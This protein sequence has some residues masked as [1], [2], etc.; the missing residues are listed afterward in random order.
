MHAGEIDSAARHPGA[1]ATVLGLA[2][3]SAAYV[4][5]QI[6]NERRGG[7]AG[8]GRRRHELLCGKLE[9]LVEAVL[10]TERE[11]E[12]RSARVESDGRAGVA[13]LAAPS[14]ASEA[15]AP[16]SDASSRSFDAVLTLQQLYFPNLE[17]AV[18]EL[19]RARD[20]HLHFLRAELTEMQAEPDRWRT[21]FA[22]DYGARAREALQPFAAARYRCIKMAR[23]IIEGELIP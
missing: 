22:G 4:A 11:L 15:G 14:P 6:T 12:S 7:T 9:N 1:A 16:A 13:A 17:P 21:L 20:A 5:Y 8:A 19:R 3:V 18:D 23:D 10:E 2:L